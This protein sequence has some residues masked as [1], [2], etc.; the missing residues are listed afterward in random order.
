MGPLDSPF[1]KIGIELTDSVYVALN[2]R[3]M[4]RMGAAVL[5]SLGTPWGV[6]PVLAQQGR[7]RRSAPTDLA[8]KPEFRPG[9]STTL[10]DATFQKLE[11]GTHL[12]ISIEGCPR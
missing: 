5:D 2:M 6:H 10:T 11:M 12:G 4:T 8:L 7:S 1:T 3:F 9:N